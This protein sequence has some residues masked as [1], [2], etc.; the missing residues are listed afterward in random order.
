M[1]LRNGENMKT[2]TVK[3]VQIS[4]M[5]LGTA[6]LGYHY[7]ISNQS[8]K[9]DRKTVHDI[10]NRAMQHGI[11]CLDTAAVYGDAEEVIGEWLATLQKEER[12]FLAT[13]VTHLDH[14]SL[15]ALR[16]DM[17]RQ[18][19]EAK[20]KL[21]LE[22]IPLLMLHHFDEYLEDARHME[23]IFRELKENGDIRLSGVSAYSQHD[24]RQIAETGLD[25][26]Q[27]P[28]NLFDTGHI[29]DG[30]IEC[31]RRSGMMV[32][33]RSVYLQGLVFLDPEHLD[34]RMEFCKSTLVKFRALCSKWNMSPAT[35]ALAYVLSL[36]ATTSLVL[37][38]ETMEQM[39]ENVTL[40]EAAPTLS[41]AQIAEVQETFRDVDQRVINPNQWHNA[42]KGAV[43]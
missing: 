15:T 13:K 10:L 30:G 14:S 33:V 1:T 32:F 19:E 16:T 21:G 24:Y 25:A 22:Q 39:E 43:K 17:R 8:G 23:Q 27:I 18:V 11:N 7:G 4:E 2:T 34:P 36:P 3:G 38:S 42:W 37:G 12:P 40:I 29:E 31:L 6:Q 26:V 20:S 28:L 9:P 41:A 35:L 5:S